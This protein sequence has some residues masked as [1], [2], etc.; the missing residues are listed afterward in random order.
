[1]DAQKPFDASA[2]SDV[3]LRSS[4]DIDFFVLESLL[5]LV[6]PVFCTLLSSNRDSAP[7]QKKNDRPI[8]PVADDSKTLHYLLSI[9]YPYPHQLK[10]NDCPLLL[11]VG[12][13]VQKYRMS[14]IENKL[15]MPLLSSVPGCGVGAFP[16]QFQLYATLVQLGWHHEATL[17]ARKTLEIPLRELPF[18]DELRGINGADFYG[19]L[20]LKFRHDRASGEQAKTGVAAKRLSATTS[21]QP[22]DTETLVS[23]TEKAFEP[24]KD[25]AD[26]IFRSSDSVDFFVLKAVISLVSP[27][28]DKK[29]P[30]KVGGGLP[31]FDFEED[32]DTLRLLLLLIYPHGPS[33]HHINSLD[34]YHKLGKAT[35]KYSM[36]V[37]E[38]KVKHLLLASSFLTDEPLCVFAISIMLGWGEVVKAAALST[39]SSPLEDMPYVDEL[40]QITGADLYWL[41]QYR[42][43]C[44]E[45]ACGIIETEA[46]FATL[47]L[48]KKGAENSTVKSRILD[49]LKSCPRGS[50]IVESCAADLEELEKGVY[51]DLKVMIRLMRKR[52]ILAKAVEEAISRVPLEVECCKALDSIDLLKTKSDEGEDK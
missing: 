5:C 11:K 3:I 52:D 34:A 20:N 12:S 22:S 15:K 13:A 45:A 46:I 27:T 4:D 41:V 47:D 7:K 8:V 16:D 25:A 2:Y 10:L 23:R 19:Y 38:D 48:H 6:S 9:I 49:K 21:Q 24:P 39:L 14:T 28:L 29:K 18:I 33:E 44:I 35:Q 30:S 26:A 50:S 43:Q 40:K 36:P 51:W 42:F 17:A 32:S 31:I 37:I 1:M